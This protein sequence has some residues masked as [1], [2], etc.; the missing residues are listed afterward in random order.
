MISFIKKIFFTPTH[1]FQ[2]RY[3]T[4]NNGSDFVWRIIYDGEEKLATHIDI[5]GYVYGEE[6]FLD[7]ERKLNIACDGKIV[8]DKTRATIYAQKMPRDIV[9]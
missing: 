9:P 6:S 7:G 1:H 3:N 5:E 2:I 4:K 8:W